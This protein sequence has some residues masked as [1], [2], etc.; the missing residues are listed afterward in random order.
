MVDEH[1]ALSSTVWMLCMQLKLS[2]NQS[3][4]QN[5]SKD[6]V[7]EKLECELEA[8]RGAAETPL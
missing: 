8:G 5:K 1:H 2:G 6:S 7:G 4:R 3:G